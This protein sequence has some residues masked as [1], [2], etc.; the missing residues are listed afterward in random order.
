[1]SRVTDKFVR[2][3][4]HMRNLLGGLPLT[5][6]LLPHPVTIRMGRALHC[7]PLCLFVVNYLFKVHGFFSLKNTKQ[8]GVIYACTHPTHHSPHPHVWYTY[9]YMFGGVLTNCSFYLL[10]RMSQK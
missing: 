8:V 2:A 7:S 3:A 10:H 6:D 5:M 9:V 1:V 4:A